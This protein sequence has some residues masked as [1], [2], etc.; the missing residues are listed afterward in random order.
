MSAIKRLAQAGIVVK[1]L[2]CFLGVALIASAPAIYATGKLSSVRDA[3]EAA[4][5]ANVEPMVDVALA[6]DDLQRYRA[7]VLQ[8]MLEPD[9]AQMLQLQNESADLATSFDERL[10]R[11]ANAVKD[12]E[13]QQRVAEV[14]RLWPPFQDHVRSAV[15][16]ASAAGRKAEAW[17]AYRQSSKDFHDLNMALNDLTSG[18]VQ[19]LRSSRDAAG[20]A[21]AT[22]RWFAMVAVAIGLALAAAAA[23]V[24][25]SIIVRPVRAVIGALEQGARGK[26]NQRL[27]LDR[28]DE[29]GQM[30]ASL[31]ETFSSIS[32]ALGEVSG[33]ANQLIAASSEVARVSEQM[34]GAAEETSTQ[35][36]VVSAA[37]EQ[38]SRNLQT[39]AA[40]A[41]QM[42]ST[43][44]E[45]AR[46]VGQASQVAGS[47]VEAVKIT[48]STLAKL[49]ESS[50]EIGKV[51]KVITAIAAQTKLLALNATIEA[52]RAGESGKGFAVVANE[53]KELATQTARATD[54]IARRVD[55][56]QGDSQSA[57]G[58]VTQ[59]SAVV[60][61]IH[62]IQSTISS[63][64][65]EQAATTSEIDRN[66]T[67]AAQASL[68]IANN[69]SGVAK[70]AQSAAAGAGAGQQ[71]AS[72]LA[73]M[74]QALERLLGRFELA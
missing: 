46:N 43:V 17:A 65:E 38:V 57:V 21:A 39:V 73:E 44:K 69:I 56:I 70:A 11:F 72:G 37:A 74:A 30:A 66:V 31:T 12:P 8:H 5:T 7:R 9:A 49:G 63:S 67:E 16:P 6:G 54:E 71:A 24:I 27:S 2:G 28:N 22:A 51:V 47:A 40:A 55:A 58:A 4:F 23:F 26:L 59:I 34:A 19:S 64:V 60:R 48:D 32:G 53:V 36:G 50:A 33:K 52:A 13:V 1:L 61:Q 14:R 10:G 68:Q 29:V 25:A 35:A 15:F 62:D 42:S 20:A 3:Y 41:G 18:G 45:I